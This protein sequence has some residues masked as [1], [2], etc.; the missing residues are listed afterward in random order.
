MV[1][2]FITIQ[3]TSGNPHGDR[4]DKTSTATTTE[5]AEFT[6]SVE[7]GM[8]SCPFLRE[9]RGGGRKNIPSLSDRRETRVGAVGVVVVF[10]ERK[11]ERVVAIF[12]N[13]EW[14]S[15]RHFKVY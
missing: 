7:S 2:E 3:P 13:V 5:F 1:G 10:E 9:L 6:L 14:E 11:R 4:G 8:L 15:E 12:E